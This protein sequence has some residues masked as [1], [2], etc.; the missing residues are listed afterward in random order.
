MEEQGA[1][2]T[3]GGGGADGLLAQARAQAQAEAEVATRLA[4]YEKNTDIGNA[5]RLCKRWQGRLLWVHGIGWMRYDGRRWAR[6]LRGEEVHA[7]KETAKSIH[8]EVRELEQFSDTIS[9]PELRKQVE[10][11]TKRLRKHAFASESQKAVAAMLRL[12]I[13]GGRLTATHDVLDADPMLLNCANGTL[14]LRTFELRPHDPDDR[15]TKITDAAYDPEARSERWERFIARALPKERLRSFVQRAFGAALEGRFSEFLLFVWG[16]TKTSKSTTLDVLNLHVLGDYAVTAAPDLL[17]RKTRGLSAGD[18]AALVD[19]RGARL[20]TT[21]EVEEGSA[22][23]EGLV[24]RLT[25]EASMKARYMKQ[26][27]I[28]FVNTASVALAANHKPDIT[29]RD[30]AIWERIMLVTFDQTVPAGER[31]PDMRRKLGE[32]RD[33]ILGWL[34]EGLRAFRAEGLNPPPEVNKAREEYAREQ[35]MF[36]AWLESECE[37]NPDY[38]ESSAALWDSYADYARKR[39]RRLGSDVDWRATMAE[40]YG[41]TQN[42]RVLIPHQGMAV[43]RGWRGLRLVRADG[44]EEG[45]NEPVF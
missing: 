35:D 44:R 20:A 40:R 7:A 26:N 38:R 42:V 2:E 12:A 4:G 3:N 19:L 30:R 11:E 16:P 1:T 5:A 8:M 18:A 28:E 27:W 33:A 29:G 24:K 36:L 45:A 6:A 22:F 34:V 14:D 10:I 31:D 21:T 37:F 39:G 9:T 17:V 23:A 43:R 15:L 32:E 13:D 25:G 41:Q